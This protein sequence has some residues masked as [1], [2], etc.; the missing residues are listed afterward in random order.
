MWHPVE[1]LSTLLLVILHTPPGEAIYKGKMFKRRQ[2]LDLASLEMENKATG[3]TFLCSGSLVAPRWVLTSASCVK[4]GKVKKVRIRKHPI[5]SWIYTVVL[6]HPDHS[7]V[8]G[9]D[10]RGTADIALVRIKE[11]WAFPVPTYGMM[12][13]LPLETVEIMENNPKLYLMGAGQVKL[14]FTESE[15][16]NSSTDWRWAKIRLSASLCEDINA[17][18]H[19]VCSVTRPKH[20]YIT[21]EGDFGGPAVFETHEKMI[22]IAV[23]SG[24]QHTCE[25]FHDSHDSALVNTYTLVAPFMPWILRQ[26][27]IHK[28]DE[29]DKYLKIISEE[30]DKVTFRNRF[31]DYFDED[32]S[33]DDDQYYQDD[34][35]D[36]DSSLWQ[37]WHQQN[38]KASSSLGCKIVVLLIECFERKTKLH[39]H[40]E[41]I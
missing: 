28:T 3:R 22:I 12:L 32:D 41:Q 34:Y 24:R 17:V 6:I 18:D 4:G 39:R 29:Y 8:P 21:C 20:P 7:R 16:T 35:G 9:H 30:W 40:Q 5:L 37:T 38:Y 11:A 14:W 10:W 36:Y 31:L 13:P 27:S 25:A 15:K 19:E 33:F 2:P 26:F 23:L 1:L